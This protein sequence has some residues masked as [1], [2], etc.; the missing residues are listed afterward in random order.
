M[1]EKKKKRG[2]REGAEEFGIAD[3]ILN[4][5]L[6]GNS[7]LVC[8][9]RAEESKEDVVLALDKEESR[10]QQRARARAGTESA[11]NDERK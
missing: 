5:L 2:R 11:E 8:V 7:E 1:E 4:C 10:G 3:A 9:G 6:V